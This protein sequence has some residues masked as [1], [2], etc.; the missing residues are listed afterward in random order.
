MNKLKVFIKILHP[1]PIDFLKIFCLFLFFLKEDYY[2]NS[3]AFFRLV[4]K[5]ILLYPL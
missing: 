2:K 5:K 3:K 4:V 1:L